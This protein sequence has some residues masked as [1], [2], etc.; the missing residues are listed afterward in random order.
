MVA[1]GLVIRVIAQIVLS[2]LI[3]AQISVLKKSSSRSSQKI[4]RRPN[5]RVTGVRRVG[6]PD[7]AINILLDVVN[8]ALNNINLVGALGDELLNSIVN[9]LFVVTLV[10]QFEEV[11]SLGPLAGLSCDRALLIVVHVDVLD[12]GT[13]LINR[14]GI[15]LHV[16]VHRR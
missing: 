15:A 5:R 13:R 16:Q 1:R 2:K 7:H 12:G 4:V 9:L 6:H 8:Q 11:F 14:L 10:S 3:G